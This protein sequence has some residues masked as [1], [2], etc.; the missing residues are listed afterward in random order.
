MADRINFRRKRSGRVVRVEADSSA[1]VRMEA[2][3]QVWEK[4]SDNVQTVEE[5]ARP[6]VGP[7]DLPAIDQS[8]EPPAKA[9][10]KAVWVDYAVTQGADRDEAEAAT[11]ADL[12]D[13]YS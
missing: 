7:G 6:N 10:A 13:R 3:S 4:V 2:E 8:P 11:K 1:A 9:D 5:E 12:V